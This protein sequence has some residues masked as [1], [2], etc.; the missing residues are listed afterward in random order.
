MDHLNRDINEAVDSLLEVRMLG[1]S[2]TANEIQA[3]IN[4][5]REWMDMLEYEEFSSPVQDAVGS[6][7]N[8]IHLQLKALLGKEPGE[9]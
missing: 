3:Q 7:L 4:R 9:Y 2:F 5:V 1:G 8:D 6:V